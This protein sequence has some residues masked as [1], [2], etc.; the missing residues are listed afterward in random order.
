ML[1]HEVARAIVSITA[2]DEGDNVWVVQQAD[3][4]RSLPPAHTN[5]SRRD[6]YWSFGPHQITGYVDTDTYEIGVRIGVCGI[7]VDNIYGNLKDGVVLK[8]NLQTTKGEIRL[9]LRNG[10]EVWT[11]IDTKV[12]FDGSFEK[13]CKILSF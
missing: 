11:H 7:S 3:I 6:I 2:P 9:Y 12:V 5:E 4:A 10:N 13:D 8:A 1:F